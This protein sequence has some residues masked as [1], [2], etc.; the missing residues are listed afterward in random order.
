MKAEVDLAKAVRGAYLFT[1]A[2]AFK[3][4]DPGKSTEFVSTYDNWIEP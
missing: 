4:A 2:E 3:S 1:Q